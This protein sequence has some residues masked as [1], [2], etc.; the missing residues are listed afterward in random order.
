MLIRAILVTPTT[1]SEA[2]RML[3]SEYVAVDAYTFFPHD[4]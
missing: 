4:P 1:V 3:G 2:M